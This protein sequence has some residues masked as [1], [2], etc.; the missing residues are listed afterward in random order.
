MLTFTPEVFRTANGTPY[1]KE[2]GVTLLA[3]PEFIPEATRGF[4]ESFGD[5]FDADDYVSDFYDEESGMLANDSATSLCKFAGQL[6]YLS[7]GEK[8]SRSADAKR[9]F[10]NIKEQFHGSLFH[11]AVFSM[12][13]YGIDRACSHE[14]VRHSAGTGY[15]QLSQRYVSGKTLRFVERVEYQGS[16][17]LHN[18]FEQWIDKSRAQYDMRAELLSEQMKDQ[19]ANLS[20]TDRRKAVN[21]A[22]RNCLPN[23]T[24][25]AMVMTGNVRAWRHILE[26]RASSH[27]DRPISVV[28]LRVYEILRE[29]ASIL[30]DD[31]KLEE[32]N[33]R[34]GLTTDFRKV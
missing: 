28:A 11:H 34:Q 3:R 21:Q 17:T 13:I 29:A 2:P 14:I 32:S 6:C 30:F 22:A 33:G 19:L 15:S 26:M 12:L 9:Y 23:E 27:A 4:I 8:R 25:T 18:V 16:T 5:V 24:E 7:F 1:L 31:Y 20:S 10:D